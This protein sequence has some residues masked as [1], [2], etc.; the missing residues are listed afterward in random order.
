MLN[1]FVKK[2]D[3]TLNCHYYENKFFTVNPGLDP[4]SSV[5]NL[6]FSLSRDDRLKE[7]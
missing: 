5:L 3:L 7:T 1:G 4:E 2:S 6:S